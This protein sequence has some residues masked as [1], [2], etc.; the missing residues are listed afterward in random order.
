VKLPRV[1]E[2][3]DGARVAD[4]LTAMRVVAGPLASSALVAISGE[5]VGTVGDHEPR[6]LMESDEL[7]LFSP[8]AGG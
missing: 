1:L 4:A 5:H 6:I 8:V 3:P 2:L 7:L